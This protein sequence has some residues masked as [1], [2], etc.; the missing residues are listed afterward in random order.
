MSQYRHISEQPSLAAEN[1]QLD[2]A[3][4]GEAWMTAPPSLTNVST[5][6]EG[7]Q[8]VAAVKGHS[9]LVLPSARALPVEP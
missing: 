6:A 8:L 7:A 2:E 5:L 9:H 3:R 4:A 1:W